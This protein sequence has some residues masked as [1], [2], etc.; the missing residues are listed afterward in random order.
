MKV[1][2]CTH[3]NSPKEN[4]GD[5]LSAYALAIIFGE[6]CNNLFV[7]PDDIGF[8]SDTE[9]IYGGGG[10]I[11]PNFSNRAVFKDFCMGSKK[12]KYVIC[13]VGVNKDEMVSDFSFD[14]L[15]AL[16]EWIHGAYNVTVRDTHT[17]Q[18][19]DNFLSYSRA[20]VAPCPTYSVL[21]NITLT[22][23]IKKTFKLGIV[24][25]FGHTV[26]YLHYLPSTVKLV[27]GLV[28]LVGHKN[29]SIICHD[30]Q[31]FEFAHL[32]FEKENVNICKPWSFEEVKHAYTQCEQVVSLRGHGLIFS[33]A[34]N[35]PC[36]VVSLNLKMNTLFEFHYGTKPLGLNFN[37]KEHLDFLRDRIS[38]KLLGKPPKS[39]LFN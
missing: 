33:A 5:V 23:N 37:P 12:R 36:S 11:R 26:T 32:L 8:S 9:V 28:G 3:R 2:Y 21:Q 24:P 22:T 20:N 16:Q 27:N 1:V 6:K 31:D 18:F 19:L 25:S 39:A 35:L 4:I 10:M 7:L 17:K 29:V 15:S 38:P 34:C 14:D 13:G 30:Q